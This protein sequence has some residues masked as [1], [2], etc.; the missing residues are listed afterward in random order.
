MNSLLAS[1][2]DNDLASVPKFVF[3]TRC[4]QERTLQ[5]Q[6]VAGLLEVF[7]RVNVKQR[8]ERLVHKHHVLEVF[9]N[10]WFRAV[11]IGA[12]DG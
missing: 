1:M 12:Q 11:T 8:L 6:H 2:L 4:A 7:G 3:A 10:Q 9:L 5:R